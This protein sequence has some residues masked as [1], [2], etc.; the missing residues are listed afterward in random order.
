MREWP[1]CGGMNLGILSAIRVKFRFRQ[2]ISDAH[3]LRL[4]DNRRGLHNVLSSSCIGGHSAESGEEEDVRGGS[5]LEEWY[6][7]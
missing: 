5:F 7:Q 6:A 1:H 3:S 4:S 2:L